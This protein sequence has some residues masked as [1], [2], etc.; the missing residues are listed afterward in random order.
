MPSAATMS[1]CWMPART[2]RPNEVLCNSS[3]MPISTAATTANSIS[4]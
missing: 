4:R 1:G 3:Q 2:T